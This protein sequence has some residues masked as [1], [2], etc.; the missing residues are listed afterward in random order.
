[1]SCL[2]RLFAATAVLAAFTFPQAEKPVF[3]Y[4]GIA[5]YGGVVTVPEGVEPPAPRIDVV[6]DVTAESPFDKPNR[7]LDGVARFINLCAQDGVQP[8]RLV[9]VL[10]GGATVAALG[11]EAYA[12]STSVEKNPN[13]ELLRRL[14]EA[15][16]T[17]LVCGQSLAR[18][19]YAFT[20]AAPETTVAVSAMTVL[21]NKQ[22]EGYAYLAQR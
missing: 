14:R 1:M 9:A 8:G 15:G 4:P 3:D 10:H 13:R 20:D 11:D 6:F 7:G 22:H 16:V 5:E 12:R 2:S 17:V 19:G 21:A 18:S